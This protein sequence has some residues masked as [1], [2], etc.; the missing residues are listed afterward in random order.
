MTILFEYP[1]SAAFG[2]VLPKSKIYEHTSPGPK[3]KQLFIRQV[4]QVVW[5]FKLAP[6]TVNLKAGK[7]V[8]EIQIFSIAL[9][10][11]ELKYEVLRCIDQAI[12]FPIFFE[13]CHEAKVKSIAAYK[14]PSEADGSKWVIS[15]YFETG[16]VR[17][18][19]PRKPLPMVLDLQSLYVRLLEPLMPF[20]S[21]A[22]EGLRA[23]VERMEQISLK[24]G[25]VEKCEALLRKEKQFNRKVAINAELRVLK[26]ELKGL[27]R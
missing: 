5:Q 11:G 3:L 18:D 27:T 10:G 26:Q 2:R 21:R 24:R 14:R 23:C 19:A 4:E 7:S 13:L 25:E 6:E 9:K 22:D 20:S 15:D 17:S 8:L 12:P 16:W 1:K